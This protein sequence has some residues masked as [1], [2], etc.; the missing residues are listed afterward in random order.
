MAEVLTRPSFRTSGDLECPVCFE[1]LSNQ[2]AAHTMR[3]LPC[4]HSFCTRCA[5]RLCGKPGALV[6]PM[7]RQQHP[8]LVKAQLA[9]AIES[10]GFLEPT[11]VSPSTEDQDNWGSAD[12]AGQDY[13]QSGPLRTSPTALT[14]DFKR[15]HNIFANLLLSNHSMQRLAFK[16]R[17]NAN[18]KYMVQPSEGFI[19]PLSEVEVRV[20]L[21][22][23]PDFPRKYGLIKDKFLVQH[24][25]VDPHVQHISTDMFAAGALADAGVVDV[26]V[27]LRPPAPYSARPGRFSCSIM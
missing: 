12:A 5:G 10:T 14:F 20:V 1:A 16:M 18:K 15:H 26:P 22:F 13:I 17:S 4:R 9:E 6:C 25:A 24:A 8:P 2:D 3:S 23:T 7:C 19:E 21:H 11:A 27:F